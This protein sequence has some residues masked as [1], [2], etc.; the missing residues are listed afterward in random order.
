MSSRARNILG[1]FLTYALNG[2][3]IRL[4]AIVSLPVISRV[5]SVGDFGA[6]ETIQSSV[7]LLPTIIGLG[8]DIAVMK[9]LLLEDDS[10]KQR[11]AVFTLTFFLAFWGGIITGLGIIFSKELALFVL[12]DES[13]A[14][15]VVLS[16]LSLY[17]SIFFGLA[18]QLLRVEFKVKQYTILNTTQALAQYAAIIV[19]IAVFQ[20][21]VAGYFAAVLLV[22]VL[23][24]AL[25]IGMTR[26]FYK[27]RFDKAVLKSLLSVGI[28]VMFSSLAYWVINFSDRLLLTQLGSLTETGYYSMA[29][30]MI[31]IVTLAV[32]AFSKAWTPRAF[33]FYN[34]DPDSYPQATA[35][36]HS[37]VAVSITAI[38]LLNIAV[39]RLLILLFATAEY[40]PAVVIVAPLALGGALQCLS[41][42]SCMGIYFKNRTADI[43]TASWIAAILNVA[44]NFLLIPPFGAIAAG[45]STLVSY[46]FL[47]LFYHHKTCS[48]LQCRIGIGKPL[49]AVGLGAAFAIGMCLLSLDNMFLDCF[50]KIL[51]VIL[52]CVTVFCLRLV[53][54]SEAKQIIGMLRQGG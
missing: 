30:K 20:W 43:G 21:G 54:I 22:N 8:Y 6:V 18:L 31:A 12:G 34:E 49:L 3:A 2:V 35:S 15:A 1:D 5:F 45:I 25:A 13:F 44:L 41:Q 38:A 47:Y 46:L 50:A 14:T 33:Q 53:R 24:S 29:V 48:Y 32:T 9:Q 52:Y 17:S 10:S 28:P 26:R 36:I 16:L 7:A 37:M 39:A 51:L 27:G 40:L 11:D 4:I 42:F 23:W 19:F